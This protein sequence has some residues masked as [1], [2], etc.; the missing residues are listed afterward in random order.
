[1]TAFAFPKPVKRATEKRHKAGAHRA[2]TAELRREVMARAKGCCEACGRRTLHLALDHFLGGAGRRRQKQ[3]IETTWALCA[4]PVLDDCDGART[5]NRPS[6]AL[7][8]EL[9]AKHCEKQGY[10]VIA[11]VEHRPVKRGAA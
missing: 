11:H 9:F 2:A 1:M 3:S 5:H 7:W 8:N 6:A 4:H 10:P